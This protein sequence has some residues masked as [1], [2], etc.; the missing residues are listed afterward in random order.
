M[1]KESSTY[2]ITE[3]NISSV[4]FFTKNQKI[5]EHF[6]PRSTFQLII[7]LTFKISNLK[8][9]PKMNFNVPMILSNRVWLMI[10]FEY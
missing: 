8:N 1:Y 6:F 7:S 10:Q 5:M 9:L 3:Q 2:I 4:T